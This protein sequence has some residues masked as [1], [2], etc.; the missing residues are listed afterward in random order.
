M[1]EF[2][3]IQCKFCSLCHLVRLES[4]EELFFLGRSRFSLRFHSSKKGVL[5]NFISIWSFEWVFLQHSANE[6]LEY[7]KLIYYH[8]LGNLLHLK[9]LEVYFTDLVEF[10]DNIESI[11]RKEIVTSNTRKL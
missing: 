6:S 3:G 7:N 11:T 2:I 4:L 5:Q 10:E 9:G 8:I 1:S